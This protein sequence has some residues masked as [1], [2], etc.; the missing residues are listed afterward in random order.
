MKFTF[1]YSIQGVRFELVLAVQFCGFIQ[2]YR[3]IPASRS[4]L[5]LSS[6]KTSN[7]STSATTE[8]ITLDFNI[9]QVL[10]PL[11]DTTSA[12]CLVY[13]PE[14]SAL[15]PSRRLQS[16]R[17]RRVHAEEGRR[18]GRGAHAFNHH[19]ADSVLLRVIVQSYQVIQDSPSCA[20]KWPL[21]R[22]LPGSPV[23]SRCRT[24]S[25]GGRVRRA[26]PLF[27]HFQAIQASGGCQQRAQ[28]I[29]IGMPLVPH[30]TKWRPRQH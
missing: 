20:V 11:S 3:R 21:A 25:S 9:Y 18:R 27:L 2:I 23:P 30:F 28:E 19:K 22:E 13:K 7:L 14:R 5:F 24:G 6:P 8:S 4:L 10:C 17:L 16:T 26:R 1:N 12:V 29:G 15:S